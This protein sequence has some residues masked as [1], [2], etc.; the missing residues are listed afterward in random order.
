MNDLI[1]ELYEHNRWANLTLL[2][3]C[4][5]LEDEQLD[6]ADAVGFYGSIR[7]TFLHLASAEGRYVLRLKGSPAPPPQGEKQGWP[8]IEELRS[9][10]DA[11]GQE[12][13]ELA[14]KTPDD[15]EIKSKMGDNDFTFV[16]ALVKIQAIN[17]ATEHRAQIAAMLTQ[18]GHTPPEIDGWNYGFHSGLMRSQDAS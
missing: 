12:L 18:H 6:A 15:L 2:D 14:R 11:S 10:L 17:H 7:E 16:A 9:R 3:S 13:A 1:T 5:D 8:G 4:K